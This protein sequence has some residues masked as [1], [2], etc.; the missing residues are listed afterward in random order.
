MHCAGIHANDLARIEAMLKRAASVNTK[1][2]RGL[3]PSMS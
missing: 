2:N 3:T 1:D